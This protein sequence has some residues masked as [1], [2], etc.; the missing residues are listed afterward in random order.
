MAAITS[1]IAGIGLAVSAAGTVAGIKQGQEAAK[2]Q[3]QAMDIQQRQNE[4]EA[5]RGRRQIY[6]DMLAA[7]AKSE[8]AAANQGG[9]ASSALA[10]GLSQAANSGAQS[11]ADLNQ[12][13]ATSNALYQN[14]R[15]QIGS[16]QTA[17]TL[18][19]IGGG[20]TSLGQSNLIKNVGSIFKIG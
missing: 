5:Q 3:K 4:V 9:L 18:N 17:Q 15:S 2:S 14:K 13:L 11:Q 7:Q 8:A 12:N 6:R 10:G 19:A 16:G 1:L 20:L